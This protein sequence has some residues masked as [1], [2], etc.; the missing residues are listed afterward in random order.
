M[1]KFIINSVYCVILCCFMCT[2]ILKAGTVRGDTGWI[3]YDMEDGLSNNM[4]YSLAADSNDSIWIGTGYNT[5]DPTSDPGGITMYDGSEWYHYLTKDK[6]SADPVSIY[7][8]I[9]ISID[10]NDIM[11]ANGA[12]YLNDANQTILGAGLVSYDTHKKEL[13]K[14]FY[15]YS[16]IYDKIA[17]GLFTALAVSEEG[18][19]WAGL[20][21]SDEAQQDYYC[22]LC[23]YEGDTWAVFDPDNVFQGRYISHLAIDGR[24]YVWI[25]SFNY[26]TSAEIE[27]KPE[28]MVFDPT[29]HT[30]IERFDEDNYYDIVTNVSVIDKDYNGDIWIGTIAGLFHYDYRKGDWVAEYNSSN[31]NGMMTGDT[32]TNLFIDKLTQEIWMQTY[33]SS[34][35]EIGLHC[36]HDTLNGWSLLSREIMD[37]TITNDIIK[38]KK[39]RVWI[40]TSNGLFTQDVSEVLFWIEPNDYIDGVKYSP[41][42][43]GGQYEFKIGYK[44]I[45]NAALDPNGHHLLLDSDGDGSFESRKKVSMGPFPNNGQYTEGKEY[46]AVVNGTTINFPVEGE[47]GYKFYFTENNTQVPGIPD[48]VYNLQKYPGILYWVDPVN[49]PDGVKELR[50]GSDIEEYIF[51]VGFKSNYDINVDSN[52]CL[53][54]C[55]VNGNDTFDSDEKFIMKMQDPNDKDYRNGKVFFYQIMASTIDFS[56]REE[57]KY[58]F[59]FTIDNQQ[60]TG[61]ASE[62][63]WLKEFSEL[64]Y[65]IDNYTNGVD[66]AEGPNGAEFEFKVGYKSSKGISPDE[67]QLMLDSDGDGNFSNSLRIPMTPVDLNNVDYEEGVTYTLTI[68]INFSS[69]HQVGYKFYFAV[70]DREIFGASGEYILQQT[71]WQDTTGGSGGTEDD[72]GETGGD[73]G[74][75]VTGD[76]SD[77][78]PEWVNYTQQSGLSSNTVL[79]VAIDSADRVWSGSFYHS[80]DSNDP[81]G[82]AMLD[83][84]SWDGYLT[85]NDT[86]SVYSISTLLIDDNNIMW[87][88]S[89]YYQNQ[90]LMKYDISRDQFTSYK[91]ADPGV[92]LSG[93]LITALAQDTHDTLWIGSMKLETDNTGATTYKVG[94][95]TFDGVLW[96]SIDPDILGGQG[97]SYV[98]ALNFDRDGNLWVAMN[99]NNICRG[100]IV[101]DPYSEEVL[102]RHNEEN[103]HFDVELISDIAT[104]SYGDTWV[105][106]MSGLCRYDRSRGEWIEKYTSSN[107]NGKMAG[108]RVTSLYL[109]NQEHEL[110]IGSQ[111]YV[112]G[113]A[114]GE[115]G[116]S[117]YNIR[118]NTWTLFTNEAMDNGSESE[119]NII[120]DITK[121]KKS[122]LWVATNA[123][124]YRYTEGR[125][126]I[127]PDTENPKIPGSGIF[128]PSLPDDNNGCF[129]YI[130]N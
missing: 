64:L 16:E 76:E 122:R 124:L 90:G 39:G 58:R 27:L 77:I 10:N 38:D 37:Q 129:I 118:A 7:P 84:N 62:V 93:D 115:A 9:N 52:D 125:G 5:G 112:N 13:K 21:G 40:G 95:S 69:S 55:D 36:L 26:R 44:S 79:S 127:G 1:K 81:G 70:D 101:I 128:D 89:I 121:D 8:V 72:T 18:E 117:C 3:R 116:L 98:R 49:Y 4:V 109:D 114:T 102:V 96:R 120:L 51:R 45:D 91:E 14:I 43:D 53:L 30:V 97:C 88:G 71:D 94:L 29:S 2:F 63:L 92:K 46:I 31:T 86:D 68:P 6:E 61:E 80:L 103:E 108:D 78:G 87:S 25:V 50:V 123:G 23:K 48:I 15:D 54:L 41:G 56:Q 100:I 34:S 85:K 130:L 106:T 82:I 11:W 110:W 65:W 111:V 119:I 12:I 17:F 47:I 74:G 66:R 22:K 35:R 59:Q 24:G 126:A 60:I 28:I 57:I 33:N 83:S 105:G 42:P 113:Q 20:S 19:L 99:D 32:I 75:D 67:S 107:T 73:T 104:D